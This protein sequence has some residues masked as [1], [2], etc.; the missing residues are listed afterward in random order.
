M[1][2]RKLD[3]STEEVK[4]TLRTKVNPTTMKV[5]IR[6]LKSL[7]DGRVLIEA[8]TTEEINKLKQTIQEMCGG[9]LEVVAPRL[10]KPRVVINNVPN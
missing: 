9:E 6:T 3:L 1:V 7:K 2:K 10:R 8:G 5:G 4:T